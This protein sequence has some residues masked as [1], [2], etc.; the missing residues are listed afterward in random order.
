MWFPAFIRAF[1]AKLFRFLI[2]VCLHLQNKNSLVL[3]R[4][5]WIIFCVHDD[6]ASSYPLHKPNV[7]LELFRR[8]TYSC[9]HWHRWCIRSVRR[10]LRTN[11]QR[12]QRRAQVWK[13]KGCRPSNRS[14]LPIYLPRKH[15]F[16]CK[17]SSRDFFCAY[18]NSWH[19]TSGALI[20]A[21]QSSCPQLLFCVL[22]F[23]L[24][25]ALPMGDLPQINLAASVLIPATS[26]AIF[27][28]S[29]E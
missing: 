13:I 26:L 17:L 20:N 21:C 19:I 22:A 2:G 23:R 14:L 29:N 8:C 11:R 4:E 12:Y 1:L 28:R 27:V 16:H 6:F 3:F 15:R 24:V 25:P 9:G 10:I 7:L 5:I 18:W